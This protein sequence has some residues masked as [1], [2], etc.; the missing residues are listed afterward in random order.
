[1]KENKGTIILLILAAVAWYVY[2]N[3]GLG[4]LVQPGDSDDMRA[5]AAVILGGGAFEND[6]TPGPGP[7]PN[8]NV[9]PNRKDCK[10]CKG[11]GFIKQGDG[12]V[13]ECNACIPDKSSADLVNTYINQEVNSI[14]GEKKA[15]GEVDKVQF[16]VDAILEDAAAEYKK[17]NFKWAARYIGNAERIL[18]REK[19]VFGDS[20][21]TNDKIKIAKD[22]LKAK[23]FEVVPVYVIEKDVYDKFL[24]DL[25]V[26]V[27]KHKNCQPKR[28]QDEYNSGD[29]CSLSGSGDC[30]SGSCGAS[31][32]GFGFS[33]GWFSGGRRSGG[34][35]SCSS[36][37]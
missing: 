33:G 31:E 26:Y 18:S 34:R 5:T 13:T 19:H 29:S 25:E 28:S 6:D 17:G 20:S 7:S 1:M 9:K 36:C 2:N 35:S 22:K 32:E 11:T 27:E 37:Q 3:G 16:V 10:E 23:G 12:H 24:A 14:V 15:I 4:G 30:A 8:P 21:P